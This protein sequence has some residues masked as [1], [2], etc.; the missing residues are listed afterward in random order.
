MM[1]TK[2]K[3]PTQKA[4]LVPSTLKMRVS[5]SGPRVAGGKPVSVV[6][7]PIGAKK[8]LE[9]TLS[10]ANIQKRKPEQLLPK[11]QSKRTL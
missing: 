2:V 3:K 8:Q 7:P 9:Y 11:V 1:E 10:L 6:K 4:Q 5:K